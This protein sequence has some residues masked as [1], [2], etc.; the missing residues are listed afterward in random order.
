MSSVVISGDTSG[1][2]TVTVPAVA[3]TNTVTIPAST[4]TVLLSSTTGMCKAWVNF[5]GSTAVVNASY[6]VSSVTRTAAGSYTINFT[7]A[8]PSANYAGFVTGIWTGG[9][10]IAAAAS[11]GGY[12]T[13]AFSVVTGTPLGANTDLTIVSVAVIGN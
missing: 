6:N 11:S 4:G 2:V 5:V 7:T 8:M 9:P 10:Y 1:T 3:G 13:T 12:T